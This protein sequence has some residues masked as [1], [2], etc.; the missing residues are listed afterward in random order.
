VG[1]EGGDR[2]VGGSASL[3]ILK[4]A[5]TPA[6]PTVANR[7]YARAVG[8]PHAAGPAAGEA[9]S[10]AW[11]RAGGS[12]FY[13]REGVWVEA[14]VLSP[15][16]SLPRVAVAFGSDDYFALLRRDPRV[17]AWLALGPRVRFLLE[18]TIHEING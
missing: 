16:P 15:S 8:Q 2:A 6:A 17:A 18:G 14:A 5:T 7:T 13:L 1:E 12:T 11:R 4:E 3:S 10:P 9:P